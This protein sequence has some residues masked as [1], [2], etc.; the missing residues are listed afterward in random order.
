MS[1]HRRLPGHAGRHRT[2]ES[3][4]RHRA[5]STDTALRRTSRRPAPLWPK[6]AG[7][8]TALPMIGLLVALCLSPG[9]AIPAQNVAPAPAVHPPTATRTYPLPLVLPPL[10]PASSTNPTATPTTTATPP[11]DLP[12]DHT[13]ADA[14]A[15]RSTTPTVVLTA[16]DRAIPARVLAAYRSAATRMATER[17]GCHLPWQLLA[18]IGKIESGHAVGRPI[19]PDGTITSLILGPQLDGR[20]GHALVRDTDH[21][22]LDHDTTYDRAV[23]PMQFIPTTWRTAGRDNSGDQHADPHNIDDA[24]LAAAGYL[25]RSHRDLADP[26]DLRTAIYSYNPSTSYVHAVLAWTAGYTADGATPTPAPATT[27]RPT[28]VPRP[29]TASPP[30]VAPAPTAPT[31]TP[32]TTP[33][34]TPRASLSPSVPASSSPSARTIPTLTGSASPSRPSG[35]GPSA[36]A[37]AP[38][39]GPALPAPPRATP[40]PTPGAAT[41]GDADHPADVPTVAPSSSLLVVSLLPRNEPTDPGPVTPS[42]PPP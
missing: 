22:A 35:A 33:P 9:P 13:L 14:A 20:H 6:A 42:T 40:A 27:P 1:R 10:I 8:L 3:P 29:S 16:R 38:R 11:P 17:P 19:T 28:T 24:T 30:A 26:A 18:G 21:G 12:D 25:C 23:G 34:P 41:D 7:G 4:G 39:P 15:G 31:P 2:A 32:A 5:V 36:V 37:P